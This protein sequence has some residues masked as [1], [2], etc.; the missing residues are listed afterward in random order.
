MKKFCGQKPSLKAEA[1]KLQAL[2]PKLWLLEG[3][4]SKEKMD[5]SVAFDELRSESMANSQDVNREWCDHGVAISKSIFV[6]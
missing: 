3:R 2:F 1:P 6:L 4:L 5:G